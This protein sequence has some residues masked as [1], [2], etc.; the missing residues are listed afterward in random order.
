MALIHVSESA[1]ILMEGET[2]SR[3]WEEALGVWAGTSAPVHEGERCGRRGPPGEALASL[4]GGT[5][6]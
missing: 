2:P 3:A 6:A 4:G 5:G 1:A